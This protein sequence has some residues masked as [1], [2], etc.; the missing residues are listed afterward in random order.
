VRSQTFDDAR[1]AATGARHRSSAQVPTMAARRP[2]MRLR[3][4]LYNYVS[5]A[6]KFSAKGRIHLRVKV[7]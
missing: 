3:Q 4:A 6:I 7:H 2:G 1:R 5:N